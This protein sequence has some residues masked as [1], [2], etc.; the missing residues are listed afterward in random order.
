MARV[1]VRKPRS[2]QGDRSPWRRPY[3]GPATAPVD[4]FGVVDR[5]IR[6]R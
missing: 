1:R 2:A 4:E 5:R 3:L 6:L